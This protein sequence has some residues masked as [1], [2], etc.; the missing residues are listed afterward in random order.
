VA[1]V[2]EA[3]KERVARHFFPLFLFSLFA[4]SFLTLFVFSNLC[5][6]SAAYVIS[7]LVSKCTTDQKE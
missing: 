2:S 4:I 7:L 6:Y 5:C 1:S 3:N